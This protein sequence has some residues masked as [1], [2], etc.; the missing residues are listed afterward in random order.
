MRRE[1]GSPPLRID[2]ARDA[3][4]W[5]NLSGD[6]PYGIEL[7]IPAVDGWADAHGQYFVDYLNDAFAD[8]GFPAALT[9]EG[10][11]EPPAG[12]RESLAADMPRL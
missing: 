8:G 10:H 9:V 1:D 3:L 6:G 11:E 2:F 4:H 5:A 12:L 7:V